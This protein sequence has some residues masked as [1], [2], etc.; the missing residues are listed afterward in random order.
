MCAIKYINF[1][2]V[3]SF[4]ALYTHSKI[5]HKTTGFIL[6]LALESIHINT[7]TSLISM[8]STS[9]LIHAINGITFVWITFPHIATSRTNYWAFF[10]A[11]T[12]KLIKNL[13]LFFSICNCA[14]IAF[15]IFSDIASLSFRKIIIII[16]IKRF[17]KLA[18]KAFCFVLFIC[19]RLKIDRNEF[20]A[21]KILYLYQKS[22]PEIRM[23]MLSLLSVCVLC[24]VVLCSL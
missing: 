22:L 3:C 13:F 8:Y 19:S 4:L 10:E 15:L 6:S 16:P 20:I 12:K 24:G 23:D 7:R 2:F 18:S 9:T 1:K 5:P 21:I 17:Q 14:R 11:I